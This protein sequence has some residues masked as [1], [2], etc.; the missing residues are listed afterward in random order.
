M[1]LTVT[2]SSCIW[3]HPE[4][5]RGFLPGSCSKYENHSTPII[6]FPSTG[7]G[8]RSQTSPHGSLTS[9]SAVSTV[10]P[11]ASSKAAHRTTTGRGRVCESGISKTSRCGESDAYCEFPRLEN[12]SFLLQIMYYPITADI[13][14]FCLDWL[15]DR[16]A[17][18]RSGGR[19]RLVAR[20]DARP[21]ED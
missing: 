8:S 21:R 16:M 18:V 3:Q 12:S 10:A 1:I 15:S 6:C 2:S 4:Q 13:L 7:H 19:G 14:T 17:N 9:P 20:R 11:S 5:P